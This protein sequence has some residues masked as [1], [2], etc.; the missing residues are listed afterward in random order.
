[1]ANCSAFIY[2]FANYGRSAFHPEPSRF[3]VNNLANIFGANG[4]PVLINERYVACNPQGTS[5]LTSYFAVINIPY[6][7]TPLPR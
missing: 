6:G 7:C 4:A 5:L 1:M 2:T 3:A